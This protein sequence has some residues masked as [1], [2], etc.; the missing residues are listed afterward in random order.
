MNSRRERIEK[1]LEGSPEDP[2][3][4]YGLALEC[5][6]EGAREEAVRRLVAVTQKDENY[7][8]AFQQ[9]GQLAIE[10]GETDKARD[11]LE[12]GIAAANRSNASHAAGEMMG[13]LET[14]E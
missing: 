3:L 1:M 6:K 5:L 8:A 11:W 14:L 7:Q 2:F 13:L 9:L 4:L 12:R 10:S